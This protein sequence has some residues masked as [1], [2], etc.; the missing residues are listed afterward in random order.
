MSRHLDAVNILDRSVDALDGLGGLLAHANG[1]L[2]QVPSDGLYFLL[3]LI[4]DQ[5]K[6]ASALLYPI[7]DD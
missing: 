2:D 3:A 5:I 4:R 7:N 6:L 1:T